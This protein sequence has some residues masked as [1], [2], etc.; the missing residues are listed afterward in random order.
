MRLI[1]WFAKVLLSI[2]VLLDAYS[3]LQLWTY[4]PPLVITDSKMTKTGEYSF[5]VARAPLSAQD[6]LLIVFVI[7]LQVA[8]VWFLWWS[9]RKIVP[10][11]R[12]NSIQ[13]LGIRD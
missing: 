5:K 2:L 4:G 7:A 1:R 13:V 11:L 3:A 9:K 6:Y 12:Q 8:L 10:V